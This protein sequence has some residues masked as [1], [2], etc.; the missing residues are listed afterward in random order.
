MGVLLSPLFFDDAVL[1]QGDGDYN[2]DGYVDLTDYADWDACMAGPG[3]GLPDPACAAFDFGA[4][5]DVD[6]LDFGG[7][8]VAFTGPRPCTF[9]RKYADFGKLASATGI[10]A[11]I[12]T[13][14]TTLCGESSEQSSATSAAWVGVT[15]AV[16][17]QPQIWAQMGYYRRRLAGSTTI[18]VERYAE[19]RW[20]TGPNQY[21]LR[22]FAGV[23]SGTH[24]YLCYSAGQPFGTWFYYYDGEPIHQITKPE[25]QGVTGTQY[26]YSTEI[27]NKEDQM[28]GTSS[29]KCN[30]TECQFSV[31]WQ[32]FQNADI[33]GPQD[34]HTDDPA[35]WGIE[36]VSS[37]AFNVWD[38]NP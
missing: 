5:N 14:S 28:V 31:N 12:R 24:E 30:F 35:E 29:A 22:T 3:G 23:E 16:G 6:I 18:F 1:A 15:K 19:T 21:E 10:S 25:L 38:V 36:R 2:G 20:G 34:L 9:G 37:T 17:Q 11:Q 13:R 8:M 26:S 32:T 4:D 7:F 33:A 27:F